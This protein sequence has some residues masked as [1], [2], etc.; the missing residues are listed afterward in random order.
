[1]EKE[2]KVEYVPQDVVVSPRSIGWRKEIYNNLLN[3]SSDLSMAMAARSAGWANS[4]AD[5]V[6][7]QRP[8]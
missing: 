1:M 2:E 6:G 3:N 7:L 5:E 4:V 8:Q